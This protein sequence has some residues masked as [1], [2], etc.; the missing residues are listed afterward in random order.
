[1]RFCHA[2]QGLGVG[3]KKVQNKGTGEGVNNDTDVVVKCFLIP[4]LFRLTSVEI[5]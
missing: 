3:R 5:L 2:K 1:M 4:L